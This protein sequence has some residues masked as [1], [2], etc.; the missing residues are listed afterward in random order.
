[1]GMDDRYGY[2]YW[3]DA[4]FSLLYATGNS[5]GSIIDGKPELTFYTD[6]TTITPTHTAGIST[7]R[8]S[9]SLPTTRS[10]TAIPRSIP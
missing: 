4:V 7:E 9:T 5:F 1:M 8:S 6:H 10:S 2:A 3:Q